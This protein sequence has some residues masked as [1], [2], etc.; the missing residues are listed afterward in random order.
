MENSENQVIYIVLLQ[1]N[2]LLFFKD[3]PQKKG[4]YLAGVK[5][6]QTVETTSAL[7]INKWAQKKH[8]HPMIK[9]I[10]EWV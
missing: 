1:N 10:V 3:K 8:M 5:L 6:F 7:E 2:Y 9:E 4:S